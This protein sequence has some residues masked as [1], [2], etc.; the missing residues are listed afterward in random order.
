MK[1]LCVLLL[2]G[3]CTAHPHWETW[4]QTHGKHYAVEEEAKRQYIWN[5]NL[6][7]VTQHNREADE[8]MHT[9][10]VGMNKFA[11][12]DNDEWRSVMVPHRPRTS[13]PK[14]DAVYKPNPSNDVTTTYLNWADQGYVTPIKDQGQCGSCWSFSATGALEGQHFKATGVLPSLSEQNIIDC[15]DRIN[16]GCNGGWTEVAFEW[17]RAN[18]GIDTEASYPYTAR[19]IW[20]CQ[21]DAA[22]SAATVAGVTMVESENEAAMLDALTAVGPLSIA[23]DASRTSFQLYESGVYYERRC[24]STSLDHA[25]LAVGYGTDDT[26]GSDYWIVKNSWGT[27]WGNEGYIW[28]A[29]NQGNNCGVATEVCYPNV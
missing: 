25:V 13:P 20:S 1:F 5:Q 6:K 27:G 12:M 3:A 23:I 8:G 9:F 22:N 26:T 24:S 19:D 14:Y 16:A 15:A 4:K 11:D 7:Y 21:Y 2:I 10:R 18:G 17:I 28:M 29:R